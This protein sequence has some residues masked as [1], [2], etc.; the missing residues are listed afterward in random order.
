MNARVEAEMNEAFDSA[1][2]RS[3]IGVTKTVLLSRIYVSRD[4]KIAGGAEELEQL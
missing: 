3:I 2:W 4:P 1:L